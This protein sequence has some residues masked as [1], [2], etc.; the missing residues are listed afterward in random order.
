MPPVDENLM[1]SAEKI[2]EAREKL[3]S[4]EGIAVEYARKDRS[5]HLSSIAQYKRKLA[6]AKDDRQ[7][8]EY[9]F[10]IGLE[11]YFMFRKISP[12]LADDRRDALAKAIEAF[13]TSAARG[14]LGESA[15]Y[16]ADLCGEYI[17]GGWSTAPIGGRMVD[18]D[19]MLEQYLLAFELLA[20]E[21]KTP[22]WREGDRHKGWLVNSIRSGIRRALGHQGR[23]KDFGQ[24]LWDI[25]QKYKGTVLGTQ[26]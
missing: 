19:M 20:A 12:E 11:Y 13:Q 25:E 9:L 17:Q 24:V 4:T 14:K 16:V 1:A 8:G 18:A 22:G 5:E 10:R 21:E 2:L 6:I 15:S 26:L 3:L 7:A 23:E